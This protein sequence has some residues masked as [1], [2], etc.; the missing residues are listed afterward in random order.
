M[1]N[2]RLLTGIAI[3]D[4]QQVWIGTASGGVVVFDY[5][6][7]LDDISDDN[8]INL[9]AQNESSGLTTNVISSI[10]A[11]KNGE[12]WI[13]TN[14][15]AFS[16]ACPGGIFNHECA[17]NQICVPRNDGTDFCDLLLET[18]TITAI[19]VD[20]ANRKWFGTTNGLFLKSD[21]GYENIHYFSEDNSPLLSNRIISLGIEPNTGDLYVLTEKGIIS[22]RSDAIELKESKAKPY[23]YPNPVRPDYEGPIAIKNLPQNADVKVTDMSG[24]LVAEGSAN[25]TQFI[26]DGRNF[27]GK[28]VAT[29]VYFILASSKDKKEKASAKVAVVK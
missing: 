25:E 11:D 1:I 21:D 14:Q 16:V 19:A 3:D 2:N 10:V 13:G 15:G 22:Y 8:F 6:G 27:Q 28:K 20:A 23:A 5:N 24:R 9:N 26:W 12:I 4:F 17:A 18:E 7:T 29:G